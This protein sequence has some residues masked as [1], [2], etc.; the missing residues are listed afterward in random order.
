MPE[1]YLEA[2][3]GPYPLVFL[4]IKVAFNLDTKKYRNLAAMMIVHSKPKQF[5]IK[6]YSSLNLQWKPHVLRY[7]QAT[8]LHLRVDAQLQSSA[9]LLD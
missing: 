6:V 8:L 9:M 7:C 4:N 5:C 3:F 1:D 2:T